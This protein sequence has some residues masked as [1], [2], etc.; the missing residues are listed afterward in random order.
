MP[1]LANSS[2]GSSCGTT[3]ED[4]TNVW[5]CFLT[6]KSRN[7][8]RIS[9]AVNM[10]DSQEQFG[11][12]HRHRPRGK[13]MKRSARLLD[14]AKGEGVAVHLALVGGHG[15]EDAEDEA[16]DAEGPVDHAKREADR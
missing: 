8:W 5:P 12:C 3:L 9:F 1:A 15:S 7:C 10:T 6:K 11:R 4:G 13:T 16:H 2:V 14:Q